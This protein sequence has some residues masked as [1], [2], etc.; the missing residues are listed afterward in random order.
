M[1]P[2]RCG[3]WNNKS[4]R[5]EKPPGREKFQEVTARIDYTECEPKSRQ[6][7]PR[8]DDEGLPVGNVLHMR[9]PQAH[10]AEQTLDC[11]RHHSSKKE[12]AGERMPFSKWSRKC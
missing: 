11:Q 8:H 6:K 4:C 2:E 9:C 10:P 1:K 7:R 12:P 3:D 5:E